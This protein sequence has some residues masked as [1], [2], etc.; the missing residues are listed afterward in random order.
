VPHPLGGIPEVDVLKK[1][2]MAVAPVVAALLAKGT[3]GRA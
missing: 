3:G 2:D 1:L